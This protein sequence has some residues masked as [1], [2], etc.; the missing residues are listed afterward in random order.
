MED[1]ETARMRKYEESK[2]TQIMIATVPHVTSGLELR[3]FQANGFLL[4][5]VYS[6]STPMEQKSKRSLYSQN[7]SY[8]HYQQNN[9]QAISPL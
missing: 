5:R 6:V 2:M 8:R 9:V 1:R 4:T 3:K 7:E